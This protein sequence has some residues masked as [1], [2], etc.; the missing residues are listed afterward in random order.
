M[1]KFTSLLLILTLVLACVG[2]GSKGSDD[3]DTKSEGVMT[4]EEY[5]AADLDTEV[6]VENYLV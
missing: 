5:V 6:V 1:K 4:Y 3:T 2:C